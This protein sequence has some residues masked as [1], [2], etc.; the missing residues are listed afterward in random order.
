[1][2][3]LRVVDLPEQTRVFRVDEN[4]GRWQVGRVLDGEGASVLVQFPNKHIANFPREELHVRWRKPIADPVTFLSR[5]VN[6]TPRF[7]QARSAFTRV[8]T[9][10]RGA[11]L[12]IGALLSSS[13]QLTDYQFDVVR[14]VLQDPVQRYLL[15][16]EVGLGKTIEAGILIRQYVLDAADSE[17]AL[18]I[19][20]S[21]LL[22]Q[23]RQ[24]LAERFGLASWLD[25]FVTV[26]ASDD[27]SAIEAQIQKAGM[28]VVDEAH[29][30]SRA[31]GDGANPLYEV[32]RHAAPSVSRLLLLSAT[33]VLSDAAGFLRVLHLLDPVVFPLDDLPAF[34]RR[35]NSRQVVAETVA[36]L[37]PENVLS[38]ENDLDRLESAFPDDAALIQLVSALRPIVQSLPGEDDEEFLRA[39]SALRSHLSETYRLH[40]R[41]LRNRRKSVPWA[42]PRRVGLT[43]IEYACSLTR[44]RH[45]ALEELRVHLFNSAD[46][47]GVESELFAAAV[48]PARGGNCEAMLTSHGVTDTQA[49][50]LARRVDL[51]TEEADSAGARLNALKMAMAQILATP[52]QQVVVFCDSPKQADAVTIA[53]RACLPQD[54]VQRHDTGGFGDDVEDPQEPWLA[55]LN[56]PGRCRVLVC[57]ARAEEGLNLHGGRKLA[58]HYDLP[59][60]PNR[61]EQ[62]LGRIDRF[63]SGDA[64]PSAALICID[65]RDES[66]WASCLDE[67]LQ[68]FAGSIA[69]LQYLIEA[70]MRA[71]RNSWM[72]AGAEALVQWTLEIAGANGWVARERRRIEQ[73]D[74]LD[75]LAETKDEAYDTLEAEDS[76]WT[77]LREAFDAFAIDALQFQKRVEPWQGPLPPKE[78]VFRLKY[79]RDEGRQTLLPL[80]TFVSEFLGTIDT[81]ARHSSSRA[82]LTFPYAFRRNT[83]LAKEGRTRGLRPL[84]YG[85]ALVQ[86]LRSFCATDDRGRVFAMW[87]HLPSHTASD[88]SGVDLYFRFD[89]LMEADVAG[90]SAAGERSDIERALHRRADHHL[91]PQFY[92]VWVATGIGVTGEEPAALRAPYRPQTEPDGGR[93]YNLN[94]SRWQVLDMRADVPWSA[95]WTRHCR[96]AA[97]AAREFIGRREDVQERIRRAT[98]AL[99]AQHDS[100]VAQLNSRAMRLTGAARDAELNELE[101]ENLTH[102][103]LLTAVRAPAFHMDVAGAVFVSTYTPFER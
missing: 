85:D 82:P 81:D 79:A 39:L 8:V 21:P 44:E 71:A 31:G 25:D 58:L 26:V 4:T 93:D 47:S 88:S 46:F 94:P 99:Q 59:P 41:I 96:E 35:V 24:E 7:A 63:G 86:S 64:I 2:A 80:Q 13:I 72:G 97:I 29:H 62:R 40:R 34:E 83:V 1:M 89:F 95:E 90:V 75:A 17:R 36:S 54:C 60:S 101:C 10:Q 50:T 19:V 48:Q 57:D 68:V 16:D 27:L 11:A 69:S 30:L 87:R 32:L 52:N 23:W 66:A 9:A 45:R 70:A 5:R 38:L 56:D 3:S 77:T 28:L 33:P 100:R 15:A 91:P 65:D 74:A 73:Q 61:I 84:R 67:G 98:Q 12:G 53:L 42:T 18:V 43:K 49:V 20:P 103:T 76:D 14:R 51:L 55:F 78:Q 37:V 102:S 92:S 22:N 6:E